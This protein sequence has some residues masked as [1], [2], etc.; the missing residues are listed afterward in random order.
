L[1]LVLQIQ[2]C[3]WSGALDLGL[4]VIQVL[5]PKL[6]ARPISRF[7]LTQQAV[8]FLA[9]TDFLAPKSTHTYECNYGT[10]LKSLRRYDLRLSPILIVEEFLY[11]EENAIDYAGCGDHV[12]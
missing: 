12:S 11:D 5:R 6:P 10:I 8:R 7:S 3:S 4:D 9:S 2:I 1:I